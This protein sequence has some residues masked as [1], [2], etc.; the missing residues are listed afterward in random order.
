VSGKSGETGEA[1]L[2]G[3]LVEEQIRNYI[4]DH[5]GV[6]TLESGWAAQG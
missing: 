2:R 1:P 4:R 3:R 5:G 6:L